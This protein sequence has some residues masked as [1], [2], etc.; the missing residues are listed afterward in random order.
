M[1]MCAHFSGMEGGGFRGSVVPQFFGM[2]GGVPRFRGSEV[3]RLPGW[4]SGRA[5]VGLV[6]HKSTVL[7]R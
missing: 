6:L 2:G 5:R 7:Q 4:G 1:Y 3:L